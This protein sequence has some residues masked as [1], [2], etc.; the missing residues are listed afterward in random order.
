MNPEQDVPSGGTEE[1]LRREIRELQ[2]RLVRQEGDKQGHSL[3]IS[4]IR[5]SRQAWEFMN[6]KSSAP[7]SFPGRA[8]LS[9]KIL[10]LSRCKAPDSSGGSG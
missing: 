6:A 5:P 4:E 2:A 7:G 8:A 1:A 9:P 3:F 10:L